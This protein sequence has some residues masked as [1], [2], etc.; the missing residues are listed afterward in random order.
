M[1]NMRPRPPTALAA[2]M[3]RRFSDLPRPRGR[4]RPRP[5]R[6]GV[7]GEPEQQDPR[8]HA[9]REPPVRPRPQEDA[10]REDDPRDGDEAVVPRAVAHQDE[11]RQDGHDDVE[12]DHGGGHDPPAAAIRQATRH[13]PAPRP[14]AT[15]VV[16]TPK[17]K[18]EPSRCRAP[19]PSLHARCEAG[20]PGAA[21]GSLPSLRVRGEFSRDERAHAPRLCFDQPSI[22]RP[23]RHHRPCERPSQESSSRGTLGRRPY[24]RARAKYV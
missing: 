17:A 8:D 9:G 21:C 19:R 3:R 7:L 10:R 13:M 24:M 14:V 15:A 11:H 23:G 5:E 18:F 20:R 6:P 22:A 2:T 16:K 12:G 4:N 1:A